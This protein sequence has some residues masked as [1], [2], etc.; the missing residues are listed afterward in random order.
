MVAL[1]AA[2]TFHTK[3]RSYLIKVWRTLAVFFIIN[4]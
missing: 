2:Q 1:I 3:L 4:E